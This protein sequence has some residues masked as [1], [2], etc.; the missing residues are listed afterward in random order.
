MKER[1]Y[2]MYCMNNKE[3]LLDEEDMDKLNQHSD[4]MLVKLKQVI[5]HPASIISIEP[6]FVGY[7]Q[8][9]IENDNGGMRLGPA[10]PPS[11]VP[12]L[13]NINTTLKLK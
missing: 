3:Y 6:F 7:I 2:K 11:P 13:F 8:K 10:T 1:R 9:A 4:K 5:V 12:D